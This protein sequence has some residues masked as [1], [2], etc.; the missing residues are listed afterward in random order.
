MSYIIETK[1][2]PQRRD[3]EGNPYPWYTPAQ[4][5][6]YYAT[7]YAREGVT[8][9]HW[10]QNGAANHDSV[11]D[12]FLQ[13]TNGS[14]NYVLSDNKITKMVEPENVAW[15]SQSGN[16]TTISIE[17][18]SDLGDEGYRKSGWLIY[19]LEKKY[20][21]R[22]TLYP[23]KYWYNTACP[24][25]INLDRI[26]QEADNWHKGGIVLD[27]NG[28]MNMFLMALRRKATDDDL[29]FWRGKPYDTLQA[30]LMNTSAFNEVNDLVK[31]G[32]SARDNPDEAAA[33]LAQIKQIVD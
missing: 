30:E 15:C 4:S 5:N 11:V 17:H 16:P 9:H 24:G 31:L 28:T 18:Q 26:R 20:G 22:L 21:R 23:H 25:T 7:K 13:R 12:F 10:A 19:T 27:D 2:V 1:L 3:A 14:T 33:K 32:R 8:I 6:A 29:K